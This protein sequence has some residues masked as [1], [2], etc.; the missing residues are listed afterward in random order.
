MLNIMKLMNIKFL[1]LLI[2]SM[3][4]AA[5]SLKSQSVEY[6]VKAMYIEKFARF[7]DWNTSLSGEHF[8]I[9]VLGE[10]PFTGELEKVASKTKIKNKSVQIIYAKKLE[11]AK[12]CNLLF[13]CSSE[14][15]RLTNILHRFENT[16][17]LIIADS[18]G[19]CKKGVHLNFYLDEAET[20]KFEVNPTALRRANLTIEMQLL[21]FGRIIN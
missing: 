2:G 10:S 21:N 12:D 14:K 7:T 20:I 4:V 6:A 16:N 13:V 18:P 15:S 19:F 1:F 9:A 11:E 3:V 5:A 17:I 8:V